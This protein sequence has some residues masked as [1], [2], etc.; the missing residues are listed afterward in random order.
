MDK[1]HVATCC[2]FGSP[3]ALL[4]HKTF[5]WRSMYAH[6]QH[7]V[8]ISCPSTTSSI[9]SGLILASSSIKI[10]TSGS[11]PHKL[12]LQII[13]CYQSNTTSY[14]SIFYTTSA[15]AYLPKS[16]YPSPNIAPY[17]SNFQSTII[18]NL[19]VHRFPSPTS[20]S[21][22]SCHCNCTIPPHASWTTT[23]LI[24]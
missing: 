17:Q 4:E 12:H 6:E 1:Q 20:Y 19:I 21:L 10:F 2:I 15:S 18:L 9:W 11:L 8:A 14:L 5:I 16:A 13:F 22:W 24:S 7:P 23:C 3:T